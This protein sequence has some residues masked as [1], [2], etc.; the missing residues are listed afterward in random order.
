MIKTAEDK[1]CK[2]VINSEIY[3]HPV[4]FDQKGFDMISLRLPEN[5]F[6]SIILDSLKVWKLFRWKAGQEK[7]AIVKTAQNERCGTLGKNRS[8]RGFL[9]CSEKAISFSLKQDADVEAKERSYPDHT[10]SALPAP[11]WGLLDTI[12]PFTADMHHSICVSNRRGRSLGG[13]VFK[14]GIIGIFALN[15]AIVADVSGKRLCTQSKERNPVEH[16]TWGAKDW[17]WSHRQWHTVR[18]FTGMKW[19]KKELGQWLPK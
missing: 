3:G 17:M 8:D 4:T 12:Q 15:M 19:I 14:R 9:R 5:K 16:Q 6:R 18:Y 11:S 7:V 10:T 1:F 2:L 13:R